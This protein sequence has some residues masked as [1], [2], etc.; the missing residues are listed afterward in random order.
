MN[1]AS[2]SRNIITYLDL[3]TNGKVS[4]HLYITVDALQS[5]ATWNSFSEIFRYYLLKG[6]NPRKLKV[7]FMNSAA[8]AYDSAS[9]NNIIYKYPEFVQSNTTIPENTLWKLNDIFVNIIDKRP[10]GAF[11]IFMEPYYKLNKQNLLDYGNSVNNVYLNDLFPVINIDNNDDNR[12]IFKGNLNFIDNNNKRAN[13]FITKFFD[14]IKLTETNT[15]TR[16]NNTNNNQEYSQITNDDTEDQIIIKLENNE[17][18]SLNVILGQKDVKDLINNVNNNINISDSITDLVYYFAYKTMGD[19]LKGFIHK[20]VRIEDYFSIKS[21]G[22]FLTTD[23]YSSMFI[24]SFFN[25]PVILGK[26]GNSSIVSTMNYILDNNN[27]QNNQMQSFGKKK[28]IQRANEESQK[29]GTVG[30]F[31]RYCKRKLNVNKVNKKC[32]NIAKKSKNKKIRKKAVFA[33]NIRGYS[34]FGMDKEINKLET[35]KKYLL[36]NP[37][38]REQR[39]KE[40]LAKKELLILQKK[41][42]LKKKE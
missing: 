20:T 14:I 10:N 30:S 8:G 42:L 17:K 23:S 7:F 26:R 35:M 18:A 12:V 21:S 33:E 24:K 1:E 31:R 5:S 37:E 13:L 16:I 28:F 2:S 15:T 4:R 11:N 32:I 19:I 27:N 41:I 29:K 39:K 36:N 38:L 40:L 25:I 34:S 3:S 6:S 9:F 22:I